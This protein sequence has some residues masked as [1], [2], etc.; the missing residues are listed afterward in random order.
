M[1]QIFP[2]NSD[3]ELLDLTVLC[4]RGEMHHVGIASLIE[5]TAITV[6][7][8]VD[9]VVGVNGLKLGLR[10]I[11]DVHLL[12]ILHIGPHGLAI[13]PDCGLRCG[14]MELLAFDEDG[15]TGPVPS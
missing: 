4:G 9:E 7:I 15:S 2:C 1:V 14:G 13:K 12:I 5:G 8:K 6:L 3:E 10:R 11:A